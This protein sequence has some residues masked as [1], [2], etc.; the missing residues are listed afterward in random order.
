MADTELQGLQTLVLPMQIIKTSI[1][2]YLKISNVLENICL[3]G[4][5]KINSAY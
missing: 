5:Y 4:K 1:V 3:N 2:L